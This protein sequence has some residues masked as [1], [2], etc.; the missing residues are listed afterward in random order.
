MLRTARRRPDSGPLQPRIR[1]REARIV[2]HDFAGHPFQAQLSR[3][4]ASR[5]HDVLHL[6]CASY[7][8][9]KG[10]VDRRPGDPSTVAFRS[11]EL[12][13]E[14]SKY[15]LSKRPLQEIAY[16]R[17]VAAAVRSFCPDVVLS[18]N[19]PLLSQRILLQVC[20]KSR[21][22]F[23]FWQQDLYSLPIRS[24]LR[25]RIPLL[26]PVA[27]W[28]FTRLESRLLCASDA[29]VSISEDF[30]PVLQRWGVDLSK[31]T[32]IR[33]WAPVDDLHQDA[34]SGDWARRHCLSDRRVL[35]YS[36][37][38]GVKH[39]VKL[40]LDLAKGLNREADTRVVVASEGIGADWLR[41]QG[42][43]EGLNNLIVLP[44]QPYDDLR[45]MFAS[46][47]ILLV[48]L[49]QEAAQFSVP[50][51]LLSYLC[52]GR[53]VLGSIPSDNLAARVISEAAGGFYV[54]PGDTDGFI[55]RAKLLLRDEPLRE[56]MGRSAFDYASRHFAIED[57]GS[58][59]E[60]ILRDACG[61]GS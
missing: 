20:K 61:C 30:L 37:T 21:I 23:V 45:E 35:L 6:Q 60:T 10:A 13:A 24:R 15:S 58:R 33:N 17:A 54:S 46:A 48:V 12:P 52:A 31:V 39:D 34:P 47:E 14:F 28:A 44:F 50:S 41:N 18:S 1:T 22:G 55:E 38:I 43:A 40:L 27:G 53:P 29:V 32:V 42:R 2:V 51:K 11:I 5:G 59:F 16:G 4:L 19:S 9:G 8:T 7:T 25:E 49:G 57:I 56:R 3:E 36:G 26:G